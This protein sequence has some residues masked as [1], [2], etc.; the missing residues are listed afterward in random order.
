MSALKNNPRSVASSGQDS[1]R[2]TFARLAS[3]LR[4]RRR[5]VPAPL[6][7]PAETLALMLQVLAEE[8]S[9]LKR[10]GAEVSR[11]LAEA[12]A[13]GRHMQDAVMEANARL[14]ES[15]RLST[16]TA[17]ALCLL[18]A[19]VNRQADRIDGLSDKAEALLAQ[20][21]DLRASIIRLEAARPD[22]AFAQGVIAATER[23]EAMIE[24]M[25]QH[26]V[27]AGR[28]EQAAQRIESATGTFD[29]L[30][31]AVEARLDTAAAATL[32]KVDA[33]VAR[34]V[35]KLSRLARKAQ[36][37]DARPGAGQPWPPAAATAIRR[38]S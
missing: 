26:G 34:V 30:P 33:K 18:P 24:G 36:A 5:S 23:L 20:P 15:A 13:A 6:T 4:G 31:A 16:M 17:E 14:A 32:G 8:L 2:F 27:D 37:S 25:A 38:A 12:A 19:I 35:A 3:A 29:A 10:E 1:G 21:D 7:P 9:R 11:T 22:P 28:L